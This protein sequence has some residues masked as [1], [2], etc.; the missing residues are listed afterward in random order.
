VKVV[1]YTSIIGGIDKL[2]SVMPG[3]SDVEHIAFVDAKKREVGLWGKSPPTIMP[4][5][6]N[7]TAPAT[8]EQRIVKP[9]WDARRT[10]R[11]YK[12]VPHLYL[13]DAD[14]WIWVDG[15]VR[16]R[17]HPLKLIE[18]HMKGSLTTF[19]HWD[20]RCLYA[21]ASFCAKA[22]KDARTILQAQAKRYRK[23]GMPSN[24]GLA[25]TRVV[26]RRNTQ[27]IRDLNESWWAEIKR[28]SVRDQVSLPYVCWKHKLRWK[29]LPGRCCPRNTGREYWC[30]RHVRKKKQ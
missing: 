1:V 8:W 30:I 19:K 7:V 28:G 18:R 11:H 26:I 13:P 5:T 12:A 14:I 27:E 25:A 24:W 20:R 16:L 2:C 9:K 21:E 17:M 3:S 6:G 29:A 4:K 22:H 23:A 10:A 15:N